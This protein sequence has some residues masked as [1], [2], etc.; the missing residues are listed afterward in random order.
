[1]VAVVSVIPVDT[2]VSVA[3]VVAVDTDVAIAA[4]PVAAVVA[5]AF[6]S[7]QLR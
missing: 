1:N 2:D 4:V 5:H 7:E 6:G 3:S